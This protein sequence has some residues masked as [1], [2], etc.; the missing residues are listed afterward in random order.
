LVTPASIG[1]RRDSG[2]ID[3]MI[4]FVASWR[5][6]AEEG[7]SQPVD[8]DLDRGLEAVE[9]FPVRRDELLSRSMHDLLHRSRVTPVV[10]GGVVAGDRLPVAVP[11][12]NRA[13]PDRQSLQRLLRHRARQH[14]AAQDD[15][16]DVLSRDLREN[17]LEGGPVA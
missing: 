17:G 4:S 3:V 13:S 14:V 2:V 11:I 10:R 5:A 1:S 15:G 7:R 9:E 16:I 12:T 6:M 8:L